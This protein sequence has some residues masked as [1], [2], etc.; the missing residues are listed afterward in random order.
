M[1]FLDLGV[2]LMG[3]TLVIMVFVAKTDLEKSRVRA[4]IKPQIKSK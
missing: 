4:K 3:S 1:N 2:L